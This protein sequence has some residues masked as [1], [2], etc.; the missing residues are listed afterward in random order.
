MEIDPTRVKAILFD[1]MGVLLFPRSS[2]VPDPT[3]D[4]IDAVIGRVTDDP[5]FKTATQAAYGLDEAQFEA[6]LKH[7]VE[8]YEAYPPLWALLPELRRRFKL[9][10]I[11]N[12]T[13]LTFAHFNA[14][15][16]LLEQFD[17]FISS[18]AEGTRKPDSAIY[19]RACQRLGVEPRE[20]LFMDDSGDNILGAQRLEMQTIHWRNR[21]EGL[22]EFLQVIRGVL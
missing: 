11:N 2:Y 16:H 6:V 17:A 3:A 7:I 10:V 20:C 22:R 18:G 5:A 12:G 9:A 19:L 13:R 1:F 14:K 8:K 21:E 4:A 15:H